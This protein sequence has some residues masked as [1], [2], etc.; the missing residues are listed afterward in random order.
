MYVIKCTV[1]ST[2]YTGHAVCPFN[3]VYYQTYSKVFGI[4]H[5]GHTH[6]YVAII[7]IL[8]VSGIVLYLFS[9]DEIKYKSIN[10]FNSKCACTKIIKYVMPLEAHQNW[11]V[12]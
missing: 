11:Q 7:N 6:N 12:N 5:F 3:S 2:K 1:Y 10:V 9:D 8:V 4:L